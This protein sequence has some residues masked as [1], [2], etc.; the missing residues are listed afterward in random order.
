MVFTLG[1]AE[2]NRRAFCKNNSQKTFSASYF[3][4]NLVSGK[5]FCL[6]Q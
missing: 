6:G 5:G 4:I 2:C 3:L 1:G